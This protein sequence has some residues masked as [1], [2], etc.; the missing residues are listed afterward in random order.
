MKKTLFISC[1]ILLFALNSQAQQQKESPSLAAQYQEMMKKILSKVPNITNSP[2]SQILDFAKSLIGVPYRY[3]TS[4]PDKGFDC[5]GFVSYVFS[6]FGFK[7]PRSSTEFASTGK[8]VKLED[9][10]VGD[11]LIF[12]GTNPRVRKIGHVGIIYSIEDGE[13][14]FIHSTSGK[15]NGVTITDFNAY[16]KSRFMKAVSIT[17]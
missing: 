16:Y 15:A 9:A 6:N 10:K 12:T 2:T 17:E 11:V 7:V 13:I 3:A 1:F 14:K 5:S 4:N 8:P